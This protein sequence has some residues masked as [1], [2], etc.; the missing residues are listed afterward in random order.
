MIAEGEGSWE[1]EQSWHV[2]AEDGPGCHPERSEGSGS[3]APAC[4]PERSEGS[5]SMA[6]ACHPERS[7]GS[8]SMAPAC[9]PERSEGSGSMGVEMLR[10]AQQDRIPQ[11][12]RAVLLP[13]H[14]HVR[15]FRLLSP[16]PAIPA[17]PDH[18]AVAL[19]S[20]ILVYGMKPPAFPNV[21]LTPVL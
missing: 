5:L 7:E 14:R 11:Q 13:R 10:Y 18:H 2:V 8:G 15:A 21:G 1:D 12:D 3:M 20:K 19:T 9:H 6:P 16:F 4:H 17:T